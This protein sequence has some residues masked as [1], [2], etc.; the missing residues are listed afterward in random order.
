MDQK[1]PIQKQNKLLET[2]TEFVIKNKWALLIGSAA[3]IAVLLVAVAIQSISASNQLKAGREYDNVLNNINYAQYMTNRTDS[4]KMF[5]EQMARLDALIQ[6][7]PNTVGSV[8]ARL[9]LAKVL[10]EDSARSGKADSINTALSYYK[11]VLQ[12][13]VADFYKA[14]AVIGAAQCSEQKNDY[15]G[16]FNYYNQIVI[17]YGKEGFS[18]MAVVGMARAKEMLGDADNA[19]AYYRQAARDYPD[20]L[21]SRYAK[22]K[23][24]SFKETVSASTNKQG[25][26]NTSLPYIIQ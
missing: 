1:N 3:V 26:T 16:A 17:K 24:Y 22:G 21:W 18:P 6:T 10:Y 14:L 5:Q 12:D 11:S 2:A 8:R 9:L 23:I 20:S 7:Y 15:N 13:N 19:L 4:Q 25:G